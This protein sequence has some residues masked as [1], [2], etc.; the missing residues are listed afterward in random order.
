MIELNVFNPT[1]EEKKELIGT[2][3]G[4]D[5]HSKT[6]CEISNGMFR[7]TEI[8]P[9][10]RNLLKNSYPDVKIIPHTEFPICYPP[11]SDFPDLLKE[12]GCD[13]VISGNG[14]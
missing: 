13:M 3:V 4:E 12:K 8:F 2:S 11:P 14:G 6:I 10:L 5:L 1:G 9:V 7:I